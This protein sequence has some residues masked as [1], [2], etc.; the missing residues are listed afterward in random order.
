[1]AHKWHIK[2]KVGSFMFMM[3]IVTNIPLGAST[4]CIIKE[5]VTL[6]GYAAAAM[7][8]SF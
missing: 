2:D 1:M 4:N 7:E 5:R 8:K 3:N 6:I